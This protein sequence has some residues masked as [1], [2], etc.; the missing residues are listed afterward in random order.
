MKNEIDSQTKR[1]RLKPRREP[2]WHKLKT[3]G[4]VGYRRLEDGGTWLAR[5]RYNKKQKYISLGDLAEVPPREQFDKAEKRA[6]EWFKEVE[7][8]GKKGPY[9]V[10]AAI[11]DYITHLKINKGERTAQDASLRMKKHI[12]EFLARTQLSKLTRR[13]IADWHRGLV[14][15]GGD[16]EE[17][18]KSKDTANRLLSYFKAALNLAYQNELVN[19]D[20]AWR[21][22]K[23]FRDVGAARK[24]FLSEAQ[25]ARLLDHTSGEFQKL[26][27]SALLT[28]A[29]YGEI[30]AARVE[31]FDP[32][33]GVL[34]LSGKTGTRDCYLSHEAVRHFESLARDRLPTAYLHAKEDGTPW[35]KSHQ[36]RPMK[37]AVRAAK[38][39]RETT[40][41]ALRHTHISRALLAGVNAQVV[42]ENCGT[43]VRM[44]EKHYGKFL[45]SD[46]RAMFN[47][48]KLA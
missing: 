24:V 17:M 22:V 39:P 9:S 21:K 26:V 15:V 2:Y 30:A 44:I 42:A 38:L 20:H 48:V 5:L 36:S 35:G 43:S 6:R 19:T 25:C 29:R 27:K 14:R 33:H 23:A 13:Q 31:D 40:F 12:P 3:G 16:E 10:K 8:S 4:Y 41:Y 11:E 28:G 7:A 47:K 37:K 34:C 45:K 18:R 32:T 46:R 1:N